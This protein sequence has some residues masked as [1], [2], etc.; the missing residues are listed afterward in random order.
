M[1]NNNLFASPSCTF[2][3]QEAQRHLDAGFSFMLGRRQLVVP[4]LSRDGQLEVP[5]EDIMGAICQVAQDANLARQV[6]GNGGYIC[7]SVD[8]LQHVYLDVSPA[9][10]VL[11]VRIGAP[12]STLFNP[13][14]LAAIESSSPDF[15]LPAHLNQLFSIYLAGDTIYVPPRLNDFPQV[16]SEKEIL[17]LIDL[18]THDIDFEISHVTTEFEH[19]YHCTRPAQD[20]YFYTS[21]EH[22]LSCI[23]VLPM[24]SVRFCP[25]ESRMPGWTADMMVLQGFVLP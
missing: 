14:T 12:L 22:V 18:I 9:N 11:S 20:V 7:H 19:I 4:P 10:E 2:S 5:D 17:R 8:F 24:R 15:G 6:T 16:I 23:D 13:F 21:L 3:P 1:D 25:A